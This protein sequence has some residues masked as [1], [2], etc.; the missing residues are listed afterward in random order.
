MDST[1]G[2]VISANHLAISMHHT[3][4][5]GPGPHH[6][7]LL[8]L[9]LCEVVTPYNFN[10]QGVMQGW[11]PWTLNLINTGVLDQRSLEFTKLFVAKK[12]TQICSFIQ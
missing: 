2:H 6:C 3:K 8:D 12:T 7:S 10:I 9:I 11:G 1:I 5:V 4:V